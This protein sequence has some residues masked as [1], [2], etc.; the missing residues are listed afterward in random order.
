MS[1]LVSH[2]RS[3]GRHSDH[4]IGGYTKM[5]AGIR[6]LL[7]IGSLGCLPCEA[8]QEDILADDRVAMRAECLQSL[9]VTELQRVAS[10]PADI[11]QTL[12]SVCDCSAASLRSKV[13]S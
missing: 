3:S 1:S 11:W 7:V 5:S 6:E 4:F 10:T 9:C 8:M 12:A 2:I 13:V